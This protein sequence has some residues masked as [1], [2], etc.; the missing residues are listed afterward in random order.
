MGSVKCKSASSL[1]NFIDDL[2]LK[3][4][5]DKNLILY[6]LT[7][8]RIADSATASSYSE[9]FHKLSLF[10]VVLAFCFIIIFV[11]RIS[12][13]PTIK[14]Y[15]TTSFSFFLLEYPFIAH[16]NGR[17]M[18]TA[19]KR[20]CCSVF[21]TRIAFLRQSRNE[22]RENATVVSALVRDCV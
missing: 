3:L 12:F 10:F 4:Q 13:W 5:V 9:Y 22:R 2:D 1:Y 18:A 16:L 19:P 11:S 15:L 20:F 7:V 21:V 17:Q 6:I 14:V 8:R